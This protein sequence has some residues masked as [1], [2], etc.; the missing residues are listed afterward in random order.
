[1]RIRLAAVL[2]CLVAVPG[3]ALAGTAMDTNPRFDAGS[4]EVGIELNP[5]VGLEPSI[6]YFVAD[7]LAASIHVAGHGISF[8]NPSTPDDEVSDGELRLDVA[9]NIPLGGRVVPVLGIGMRSFNE[10]IKLAGV[11]SVDLEG[12]DVHVL[13]AL[14]FLIGDIGSLNLLLRVGR[15]TVDNNLTR[16]S[17]DSTFA[18]LALAYSLFF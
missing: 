1:M 17:Q 9:Y 10:K 5:N 11:T 16:T 7:N 6:G 15:A 13:G 4:W 2:F 8:D 14:R 18:D 12:V 3:T